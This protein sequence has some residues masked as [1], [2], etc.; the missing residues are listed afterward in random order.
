MLF[1]VTD[2]QGRYSVS[3]LSADLDGNAF[4]LSASAPA[5][6][7]LLFPS[8]PVAVAP[9]A[10]AVLG[11]YDVIFEEPVAPPARALINPSFL[12][13]AGTP[14]VFWAI[15]FSSRRMA[16]PAAPRSTRYTRA[17]APPRATS[18]PPGK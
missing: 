1:A 17:R 9:L 13:D 6:S 8:A 12:N 10:G 18:S 4:A 3:V 14:S 2:A 15:R 5:G 7:T 11:G 16:A